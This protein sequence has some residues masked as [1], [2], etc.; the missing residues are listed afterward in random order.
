MPH[1]RHSVSH[2]TIEF[3]TNF[4]ILINKS[5]AFYD[6]VNKIIV[7]K[8]TTPVTKMKHSCLA[9]KVRPLILI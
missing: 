3:E 5:F 9:V 8:N 4:Q 7:F 2:L 6:F 1:G